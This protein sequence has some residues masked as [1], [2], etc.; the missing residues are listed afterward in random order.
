MYPREIDK[1][2]DSNNY[3][4][5]SDVYN[6]ICKSSQI[7]RVKYEPFG[8]YFEIWT[9]DNYCWKFTVSNQNSQ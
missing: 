4:I 1:I 9:K 6:E 7:S 8:D 3:T 2:L 5:K